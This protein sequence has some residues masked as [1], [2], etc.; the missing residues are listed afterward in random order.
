[1]RSRSG[2]FKI[3]TMNSYSSGQ[4]KLTAGTSFDASP[5]WSVAPEIR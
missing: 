4:K 3:F 5:D 1:M 2:Q